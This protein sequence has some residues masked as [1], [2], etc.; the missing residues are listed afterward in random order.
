MLRA[1]AE[2]EVA[3]ELSAV[4]ERAQRTALLESADRRLAEAASYFA[5]HD[6]ALDAANAVNLRGVRAL[7]AGD[8]EQALALFSSARDQAA[9]NADPG[10]SIKALINLAWLSNR[11]GEIAR[12]AREYEALL[13]LLESDRDG[14]AYATAIGNYGLCLVALGEFDRALAMHS[15]ALEVFRARGAEADR[16]RELNALGGLYMRVGELERAL[17]TLRAA[18]AVNGGIGAATARASSL[19]M[20]GNTAAA[21]GDPRLALEYL[22]ESLEQDATPQNVAS[23]RV[24]MASATARA[25]RSGGRRTRNRRGAR[26]RQR[27]DAR[28][29][30]G[31]ARPAASPA[32]R[33]PGGAVRPAHR[34]PAVRVTGTRL[35]PHRYQRGA[36]ADACWRRTT[37]A[38]PRRPPT[39]RSPSSSGFA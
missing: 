17:E 5:A 7:S 38:A 19:R 6:A 29:R 4:T 3:N 26:R 24:L 33:L 39:P 13:P 14:D 30:A 37:R 23:T 18:S 10:L 35:R 36:V 28:A 8:D 2:I 25:G 12:A 32:A 11:R 34:R 16:G 21:L 20:A 22:R 27:T 1:A 9:A 31:G 15:E